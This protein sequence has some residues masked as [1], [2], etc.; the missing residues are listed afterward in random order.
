MSKNTSRG[1]TALNELQQSGNLI[2][3]I[4]MSKNT[5]RDHTLLNELQKSVNLIRLIVCP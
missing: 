3:L 4:L 2:R 1:H 5:S